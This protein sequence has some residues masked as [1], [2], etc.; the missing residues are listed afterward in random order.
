MPGYGRVKG[1]LDI[2]TAAALL[3]TLHYI[4]TRRLRDVEAKQQ[5]QEDKSYLNPLRN[6]RTSQRSM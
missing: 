1:K 2:H 6:R 4:L 5:T 3:Q